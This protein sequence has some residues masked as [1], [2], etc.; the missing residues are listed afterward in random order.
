MKVA[1]VVPRYGPE[2]LG[3]A[4]TGARMLAEHLVAGRGDE[5]EVF[6]TCA[7]DA[8][9]WVDELAPGTER[10]NGVKV[11]RLASAAGRDP[12]FHP[13]SGALRAAPEAATAAEAERWI[14]LQG[15]VCPDLVEAVAATDADVV[16]FYPYLYFPTVRG[17]P[18]VADRAVLHP[19]AHDEPPL[20]LPVFRDV[21]RSVRGLVFQ[22]KS[23]QRLVETLFGVA[24]TQQ[25]VVG[26]GV[27]E[28]PGSPDDARAAVGL[29]DAPYLVC[30]GRVDDKKGTGMLW[31]Y[32]RAYKQRHPGP[33]HLVL[34]GQVVDRPEPAPD[35]VVTG[36]VDDGLKWGLL[37]GARALVSPSPWEAFSIV[38][39]EAMTAGVPVVANAMCG[40]TKEHCERSGAGL[41]FSGYGQ[42][43]AVVDRLLAD[44]S[45]AAALGR[46]GRRYAEDN[47]SWPVITARYGAFLEGVA[48]RRER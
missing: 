42:F 15:P 34:V 18:R 23:E 24:T 47:Y 35:V 29:G 26:L 30:V 41:W 25:V 33:L 1:Y 16:A 8:L 20:H 44:R 14:D 17:V 12:S 7:T 27:E 45:L 46:R 11:H 5:V 32:F 39:I 9:T 38:V 6:T 22:T 36:P 43:E 3:G 13:Y 31:R 21:F 28:A 2:I 48:R 37:R 19:A 10:L 4:E 40:P